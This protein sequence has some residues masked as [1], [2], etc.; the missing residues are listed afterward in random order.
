[1][2]DRDRD[3]VAERCAADLELGR[4]LDACAP[5]SLRWIPGSRLLAHGPPNG[6]VRWGCSATLLLY[7]ATDPGAASGGYY[8]PS[9]RF[10]LVG[11]TGPARPPRR[12]QD[13]DATA[14]L[15]TLAQDLTGTHLGDRW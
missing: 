2:D 3:R 14:R 5:S 13:A 4:G 6:P 1:M 10:N 15:W 9:G 12:A 11:P 8:G 7:A